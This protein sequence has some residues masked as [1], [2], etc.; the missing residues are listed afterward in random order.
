MVGSS[1][2]TSVI[3]EAAWMHHGSSSPACKSGIAET[4]NTGDLIGSLEN[5]RKENEDL[6]ATLDT[7]KKI[8]NDSDAT[9]GCKNAEDDLVTAGIDDPRWW[10]WVSTDLFGGA[11]EDAVEGEYTLVNENDIIEGIAAFLARYITSIPKSKTMTPNQ[12]QDGSPPIL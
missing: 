1:A 4:A 3:N 8:L 10:V 2:S 5:M 6:C 11:N 9:T 7:Y 12:L